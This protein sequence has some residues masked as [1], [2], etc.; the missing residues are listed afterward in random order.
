MHGEI[1]LSERIAFNWKFLSIRTWFFHIFAV[2][3][4]GLKKL[5][6]IPPNQCKKRFSAGRLLSTLW[7]WAEV[8]TIE[9]AEQINGREKLRRGFNLLRGTP[10][11][12]PCCRVVITRPWRWIRNKSSTNPKL[13]TCLFF[14]SCY[15]FIRT[16]SLS[17]VSQTLFPRRVKQ[18]PEKESALAGCNKFSFDVCCIRVTWNH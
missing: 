8:K 16:R 15:I 7:R 11:I 4:R 2:H 1:N 14:R 3:D 9:L 13:S 17:S 12:M 6:R 5:A 18:K 10:F